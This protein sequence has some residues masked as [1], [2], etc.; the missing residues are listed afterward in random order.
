MIGVTVV[1]ALLHLFDILT[2]FK[3]YFCVEPL[4]PFH[5]F[6]ELMAFLSVMVKERFSIGK[7]LMYFVVHLCDLCQVLVIIL[8]NDINN[9]LLLFVNSISN[10]I[11]VF[12]WL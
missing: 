2:H 11:N 7:C 10:L 12:E 4:I 5:V 8:L 9:V 1:H 6:R 3:V